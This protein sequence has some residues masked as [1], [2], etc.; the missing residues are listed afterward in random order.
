MGSPPKGVLETTPPAPLS[1][2]RLIK[3]E[4]F[5]GVA[6]ATIKG[7]LN[8]KPQNSTS[9]EVISHLHD[10]EK[11]R[12]QPSTSSLLGYPFRLIIIFSS[13]YSKPLSRVHPEMDH[14]LR[15]Y[16][17]FGNS[18]SIVIFFFG[19]HTVRLVQAIMV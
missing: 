12:Q 4:F 11:K 16:M 13:V 17:Y 6:G 7:F 14:F 8:F 18:S 5:V 19:L 1:K 9:R 10:S 15:F 2:A 3:S